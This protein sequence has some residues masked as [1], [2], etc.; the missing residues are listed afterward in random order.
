MKFR[1]STFMAGLLSLGISASYLILGIKAVSFFFT[2]FDKE[3]EGF[4]VLAFIFGF[5]IIWAALALIVAA[6][7]IFMVIFSL[8]QSISKL[9]LAFKDDDD[10]HLSSA[11]LKVNITLDV[12]LGILNIFLFIVTDAYPLFIICGSLH[13]ISLIFL[14]ITSAK[15]NHDVKA[16]KV[17]LQQRELT[18]NP[19]FLMEKELKR[20]EEK[21]TS[22]VIRDEEYEQLRKSII[23]KYADQI[24]TAPEKKE[25]V[26]E[27]EKPKEDKKDDE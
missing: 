14:S 25:E 21:K 19:I 9:V 10:Y 8:I 13:V 12:I 20:L 23:D 16:G 17:K 3:A 22:G 11:T 1:F 26:V 15:F 6:F 4:K 24:G 27:I 2:S 18:I 5:W 7:F